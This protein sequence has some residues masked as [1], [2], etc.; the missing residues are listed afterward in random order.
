MEN[1]MKLV[2]R[3]DN[4]LDIYSNVI[5][6]P[7]IPCL[8]LWVK[9]CSWKIKSKSHEHGKKYEEH[10]QFAE[11]VLGQAITNCTLCFE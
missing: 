9:W 11:T 4:L 5:F 8:V 1:M 6:L 7:I 3:N 10:K 2:K